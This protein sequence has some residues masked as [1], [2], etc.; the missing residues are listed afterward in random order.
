MSAAVLLLALWL[1]GEAPR[2]MTQ[3]MPSMDACRAAERAWLAGEPD[4]HAIPT[5]PSAT[6]YALCVTLPAAGKDA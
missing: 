3:A 4:A 2:T 6:R 5:P 1:P